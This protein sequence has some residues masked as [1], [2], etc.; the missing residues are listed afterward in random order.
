MDEKLVSVI[1]TTHNR[2]PKIVL[3]AVNSVLCQ[4]YKNIEIIVVDD[5]SKE[6]VLRDDVEKIIRHKAPQI[7]YIKHETNKGSCAARN[8]GLL[9]AKG[10]YVAFLDDDDEWLPQKIEEQI[11]GFTDDN[12]ALVYSGITI[13][14]EINCLNYNAKFKAV[15]GKAFYPL[16]KSCFIG[17]TSNPL[18]KKECIENVGLFDTKMKSCQDYDLWLRIAMRYHINYVKMPLIKYHIHENDRISTNLDDQISGRDRIIKKY[19]VF[20]RKDKIAWSNQYRGIASVYILKGSKEKAF[21]YFLKC[22][23][24]SPTSIL[25]NSKLFLVIIFGY[26]SLVYKNFKKIRCFLNVL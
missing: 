18:I 10:Y 2:S 7:L 19:I 11:K 13:I 15:K 24:I 25:N 12:I 21:Y 5:S 4:T 3:R 9:Y 20:L 26:D 22:I 17:S 8:T 14:D 16:L 23:K 6:Y 1:I